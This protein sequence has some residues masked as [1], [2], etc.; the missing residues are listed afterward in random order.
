MKKRVIGLLTLF[1]IIMAEL[2]G[3]CGFAQTQTIEFSA[4]DKIDRFTGVQPQ[5]I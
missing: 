4:N 1:I 2:S 5:E 3:L